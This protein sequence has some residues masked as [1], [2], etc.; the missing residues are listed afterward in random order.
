VSSDRLSSWT[1]R[2]GAALGALYIGLGVVETVVHLDDPT[3]L[4]FWAPALLGGGTLAGTYETKEDATAAGRREA[5]ERHTEHVIHLQDGSIE[6][7]NSYGGDP[8]HRPG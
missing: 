5:Q 4:L 3:S 8:A 7:R 6:E 1:P 2:L